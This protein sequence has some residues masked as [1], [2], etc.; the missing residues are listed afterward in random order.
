MATK[1]HEKAQKGFVPYRVS[2]GHRNCDLLDYAEN[3]AGTTTVSKY[4]YGFDTQDQPLLDAA[5]LRTFVAMSGEA[6]GGPT[7]GHHWDF[8]YNEGEKVSR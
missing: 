2:C 1:R 8:G 4:R 3:K 6:F 5:C 7:T